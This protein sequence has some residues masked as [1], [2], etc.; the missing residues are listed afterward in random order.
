MLW[1]Q[2][3]GETEGFFF[4]FSQRPRTLGGFSFS[5]FFFSFLTFVL[6]WDQCEENVLARINKNKF[7]SLPKLCF[8]QTFARQ[9]AK[10]PRKGEAGGKTPAQSISLS[11]CFWSLSR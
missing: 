5:F 9:R 8:T 6:L 3:S 1:L 4:I 11:R 2:G 7:V 10:F